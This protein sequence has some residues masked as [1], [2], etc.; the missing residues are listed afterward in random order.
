MVF[1]NLSGYDAHLFVKNLGYSEGNINCIPN[2]EEKYISFT[3]NVIVGSYIDK[4]GETK[5]KTHDIRFIDSF[6]FMASSLDELVKNLPETAFSN[7]KRYY[8]G[9]QLKLLKRTGVYPYDYMD[10]IERFKENKLPSK[11]SFYSKLNNEDISDE[12]YEHAKKVWDVFKMKSM[13]DYHELYNKSDVL[14]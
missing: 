5:N 4:N 14:Q 12:D 11:E 3:K 9:D 13:M 7:T 2:N 6:K 1:H 8:T 10:S